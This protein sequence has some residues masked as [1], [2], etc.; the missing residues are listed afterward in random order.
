MLE[1]NTQD[2]LD[3]NHILVKNGSMTGF[4]QVSN[5]DRKRFEALQNIIREKDLQVQS[6]NK[7]IAG[8]VKDNKRLVTKTHANKDGIERIDDLVKKLAEAEVE[9]EHMR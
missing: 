6:L 2:Y 8:L 9:N 4:S 7:Q 3:T 1:I 5:S